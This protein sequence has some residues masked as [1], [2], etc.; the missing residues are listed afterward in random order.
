LKT[1]SQA[2]TVTDL[3]EASYGSQVKSRCSGTNKFTI[4]FVNRGTETVHIYWKSYNGRWV[5]Y[6]KLGPNKKLHQESCYGSIWAVT[7]ANYYMTQET[8]FVSVIHTQ[9]SWENVIFTAQDGIKNIGVCFDD[10]GTPVFCSNILGD[11]LQP[12]T[13]AAEAGQAYSQYY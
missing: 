1:V 13:T 7:I 2:G 11:T 6:E 4:N 9:P 3:I 8:D 5:F 10:A 12:A